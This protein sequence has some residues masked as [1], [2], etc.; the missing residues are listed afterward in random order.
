MLV[1][2]SLAQTVSWGILH[3]TFAV[4]LEP[5]EADLGW[6]RTTLT[7]AFSLALLMSGCAAVPVGHWLDAR[8]PRGLMSAGSAL[9]AVLVFAWSQV[10]TV[11]MFYALWAG[12]GL[13]MAAVLYEPAFAVITVWFLRHRQRALTVM[14]LFGGLASTIFVPL[15]AG[16]GARLGWRDAIA[17]LAM[18][19][20]CTTLP[21]HALLLRRHPRDV[22]AQVDGALES[23]PAAVAE[24]PVHLRSILASGA[25]WRLAGAFS[26]SSFATVATVVHLIPAL[27]QGG[28][29]T[30]QAAA[31]LAALGALQLPGRLLFVPLRGRLSGPRTTALVFLTQAV[32][33]ALL[34]VVPHTSGVIAFVVL[35]GMAAGM[36]T[37]VRASL[38]GE[39]FALSHY[40]RV[41]GTL[42]MVTTFARALGPVAASIA[43]GVLP[44]YGHVFAGLAAVMVMAAGVANHRRPAL[45]VA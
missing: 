16:L 38:V 10:T 29:S 42:A 1:G 7:G 19:L 22:G 23:Q 9:A 28:L 14:T 20:A 45:D 30:S 6:S 40:G 44:G 36:S 13:C 5:M 3:Y 12:L 34:V 4:F 18:I 27:R 26:L 43:Y 17:A 21:L 15:A 8:G 37:V 32:A 33:L 41:A 24:T 31:A 35:F 11:P 39:Q 25:F 2:L